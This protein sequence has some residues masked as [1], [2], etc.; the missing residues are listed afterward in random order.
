M[1]IRD[2]QVHSS[3]LRTGDWMASVNLKDA[4]FQIPIHPGSRKYLRFVWHD[5]VYQLK[6]L[7]WV[8]RPGQSPRSSATGPLSSET[9]ATSPLPSGTTATSPLPSETTS[10]GKLTAISRSG[11]LAPTV[12]VATS[13]LAT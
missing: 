10:L 6:V 12:E 1:Q 9:T 3:S 13:D 2:P 8:T 7:P 11:S 5:R 4:Y